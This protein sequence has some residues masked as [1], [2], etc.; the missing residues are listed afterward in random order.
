MAEKVM[1]KY[2]LI[3]K[4]MSKALDFFIYIMYN[5]YV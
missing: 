1:K 5:Y 2:T 4:K 3:N